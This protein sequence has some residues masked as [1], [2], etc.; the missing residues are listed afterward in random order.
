M[1]PKNVTMSYEQFLTLL[2]E[3]L[4]KKLGSGYQ[5]IPQNVL[6]TN[7]VVKHSL[8]IK[9]G[10]SNIAPSICMDAFY[11]D[12]INKKMKLDY[13]AEAAY[14]IY[15]QNEVNCPI[16]AS[17]FMDWN[18]IRN[19]IRCRIV[20]TE[21]NKTLLSKI[22]HREFLD[23]SILYYL[24]VTVP[25]GTEGTI[26]I[27]NEHMKFWNI[28]ENRLYSEAWQNMRAAKDAEVSSMMDMIG[29]ALSVPQSR[30]S[31]IVGGQMYVLTNRNRLYGAAHMTDLDKMA[32]IAAQINNDLWILPSSIHEVILIPAIWNDSA[33]ELANMVCEINKTELS[34]SEIL[35][36]HVY[37]FSRDTG[38]VSI[39]A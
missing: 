8:A 9:N 30:T 35:S 14:Q 24:Q 5:F 28:D 27:C 36:C 31:H 22:P 10:I 16:D 26:H 11:L 6:K 33:A 21:N 32:E 15:K 20:N 37:Y 7:G 1:E 4:Q 17:R 2:T 12:Y 34:A 18:Q 25:D 3:C 38:T 23:L 39:A 13:I 29:S 19:G